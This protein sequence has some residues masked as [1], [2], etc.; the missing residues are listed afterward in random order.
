VC[1]CVQVGRTG[2]VEFDTIAQLFK[3]VKYKG[4]SCR[5]VLSASLEWNSFVLSKKPIQCAA[6]PCGSVAF[7]LISS[8]HH[9]PTFYTLSFSIF[10]TFPLSLL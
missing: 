9:F 5:L 1:V 2:N 7:P 4:S 8:L 6:A 10:F 3:S